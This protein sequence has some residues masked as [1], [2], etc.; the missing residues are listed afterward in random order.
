[1]K[2]YRLERRQRIDAP[3]E[4]VFPFFAEAG[5]LELLT[6]KWLGFRF[7]TPLPIPMR[8][9]ARI[10]YR[11]RLAGVPVRWQT[12]ILRWD[13]PNGFVDRQERGPYRLWE[14]VHR[15][16]RDGDAVV[17][18]DRVRYSLP[19]GPVGRFAHAL[20]VRRALGRIFDYRRARI[21]ER[22]APSP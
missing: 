17:M 16:D 11:I 20:A 19:F 9:D 1:M 7:V 5:N 14:H 12:R 18:T 22:F 3:L 2:V 13:P 21:D 8:D 15:F 10:E 4:A 6:P